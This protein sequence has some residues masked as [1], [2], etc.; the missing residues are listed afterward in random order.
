MSY[1]SRPDPD[2]GA[3]R[4][5]VLNA[6]DLARVCDISRVPGDETGLLFRIVTAPDDA[7]VLGGGEHVMRAETPEMA[8]YF[9]DADASA[10]FEAMRTPAT[11]R[12]DDPWAV[13]TRAVQVTCIA[14]ERGN[15]LLCS[16]HQARRVQFSVDGTPT[17][18]L[19]FLL[20]PC[21]IT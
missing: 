14:E 13:V 5:K 10:A 17:F 6:L 7:G 2:D 20:P 12:A 4:A 15:G 1:S 21:R 11:R 16:P 18:V 8:G 3:N 19:P 9:V